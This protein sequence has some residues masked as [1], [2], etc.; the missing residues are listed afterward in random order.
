MVSFIL[1]LR[2][3]TPSSPSPEMSGIHLGIRRVWLS[4]CTFQ[5]ISAFVFCILPLAPA[6]LMLFWHVVPGSFVLVPLSNLYKWSLC[7]HCFSLCSTAFSIPTQVG[8]SCVQ[9]FPL[10]TIDAEILSPEGTLLTTSSD[11][12]ISPNDFCVHGQILDLLEGRYSIPPLR[13]WRD[14][15][16]S[17][18]EPLSQQEMVRRWTGRRCRKIGMGTPASLLA[19]EVVVVGWGD[20]WPTAN[21]AGAVPSN[22]GGAGGGAELLLLSSSWGPWGMAAWVLVLDPCSG[23]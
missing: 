15:G 6:S 7:C 4:G 2:S 20:S 17:W 18:L 12:R 1:I 23:M 11:C 19:V 22:G 14:G 10:I 13:P 21:T 9:T 16:K 8:I 5:F 3:N